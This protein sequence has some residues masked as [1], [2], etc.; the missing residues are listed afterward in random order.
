MTYNTITSVAI[1]A[2][3]PVQKAKASGRTAG[4]VRKEPFEIAGE[5]HMIHRVHKDLQQKN[6]EQ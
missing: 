1:K 3:E 6:G 5:N 2:S 4:D